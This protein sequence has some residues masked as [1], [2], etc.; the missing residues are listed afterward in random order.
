[1]KCGKKLLREAD[2]K[3]LSE[4]DK[5][6]GC[7]KPPILRQAKLQF[8]AKSD[9]PSDDTTGLTCPLP[10]TPSTDTAGLTFPT[11][12]PP[13]NPFDKSSTRNLTI[14]PLV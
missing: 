3:L 9:G 8:K 5:F 11:P 12:L 6:L 2:K 7:D 1:M 13:T 10:T 14:L 4:A